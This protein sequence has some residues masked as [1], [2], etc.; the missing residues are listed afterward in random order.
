M[1][2]ALCRIPV[3]LLGSPSCG[4]WT[5]GGLSFRSDTQICCL[6]NPAQCAAN[7]NMLSNIGVLL[8]GTLVKMGKQHLAKGL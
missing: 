4:S 6:G 2:A 5:E 1:A 8:C 3:S 7:V